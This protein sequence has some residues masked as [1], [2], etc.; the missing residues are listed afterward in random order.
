[1]FQE[2]KVGQ[3]NKGVKLLSL[4]Q[5]SNRLFC[6]EWIPTESGPT[7]LNYK[8]LSYN[9]QTY[10]NFLDFVFNNFEIKNIDD[11]NKIITLSL[12]VDSVCLTSFK[13]E[14]KISLNDQIQWYQ[15]NFLGKYIMDNY[16]IYY[17]PMDVNNNEVI[18]IYI[19]KDLKNNI[20]NSCEKYGYEL[21]HLSVDIF[22][23]NHAVHIYDYSA[24]DKYIL[25]KIGKNNNH[26][27]LY[28]ERE[29][30]KHYIKLKYGKKI[31]CIQSIGENSLKNDLID[32]ISSLLDDNTQINSNLYDKIY[33]YQS[34]S[35]FELLKKIYN[36]NKNK[37]IIMD[38]GSKFLN[39]GVTR[40]KNNYNLF[41][42]NENGNS[43]RG[44]DV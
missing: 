31:E 30:L 8:K 22:S 28:Y 37:I 39:K 16:D 25:W 15:N 29:I 5:T 14:P 26:Y 23:A 43:L 7:V 4:S 27:L 35:N 33:L 34:K 32:L 13:Y 18:V 3:A 36:Q 11:I 1:M 42:Y 38:I 41:G 20:L 44:I 9:P 10:D 24:N 21:R 40:K 17:Y 6:V 19:S 2:L 12:D